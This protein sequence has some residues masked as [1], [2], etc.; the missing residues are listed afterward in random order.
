MLELILGYNGLG[1]ITG[2]ET[3]SVT[4][5]G[6]GLGGGSAWGETGWSRLFSSD[7]GG[8]V[9]WLIPAAIAAGLALLWISRRAPRTDRARA[10]AMLWLG[11]LLLTGLTISFA[12]G[13]IHSYY[14]VALAPAIG[15]L[16]GIGAVALWSLRSHAA[17]RI[18]LAFGVAGTALW[19]SVLLSRS[20]EWMPWL[21]YAV[22]ALGIGS[23][24]VILVADRLTRRLT[25]VVAATALVSA[26]LA[27][28]AYSLQT[29]ATAH[30]GS[31]PSAGPTVTGA[32]GFGPGGGGGGGPQGG[33]GGRTG[34]APPSFGGGTAPGG[35]TTGNTTRREP[36]AAAP[37]AAWAACSTPAPPGP[38]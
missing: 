2:D 22:L 17:A 33:F 10:N 26:L 19:A 31:L 28:T 15:A 13:I 12:Q 20:A 27:P 18:A 4:G 35:T 25:T 38:R 6:G 14:T 32:R 21:R 37:A 8:Q 1:R 29:A 3:G 7:Y 5:G 9:A 11:W 30:T 36:G 24:L 16:V 23:A 34:Q